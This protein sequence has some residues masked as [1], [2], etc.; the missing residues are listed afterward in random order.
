MGT[1]KT[2]SMKHFGCRPWVTSR[3]HLAFYFQLS[4][5]LAFLPATVLNWSKFPVIFQLL[6]KLQLDGSQLSWPLALSGP[7]WLENQTRD[8]SFSICF[9][10]WHARGMS[11]APT[12][13]MYSV[14]KYVWLF[15]SVIHLRSEDSKVP[16]YMDLTCKFRRRRE[17]NMHTCTY[18]QLYTYLCS[19]VL[20]SDV[21]NMK[22]MGKSMGQK[23]GWS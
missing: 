13:W 15:W 14:H 21:K 1:L 20:A 3:A 8:S 18:T 10:T 19:L 4:L 6:W 7:L 11:L 9:S 16:Y 17:R 23:D 22:H 2:A 12:R 5:D